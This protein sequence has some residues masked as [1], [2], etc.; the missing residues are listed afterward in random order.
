[1]DSQ[2]HRPE[3]LLR[4]SS[5]PIDAST[6]PRKAAELLR[7][8]KTLMLSDRYGTGVNI[9]TQLRAV[10]NPPSLKAS[11]TERQSFKRAFEQ[12][13]QRLLATIAQ[14]KVALID[15]P[16]NGFYAELYPEHKVFALPFIEVQ[17]LDSAWQYYDV[18]VHMTVLGYRIYPFY[19]TYVP[20]RLSHL[21]LFGTWLA[22]YK[23]AHAQAIDVGTGCGVLALMMCRRGFG[24]V[25]ATDCSPNA[26]E[27]VSREIGRFD[28]P[29][30]LSLEL[31]DLLG[32]GTTP[33]DVIVFNPPWMQGKVNGP[34]DRAL[35]YEAGLF[36]R[37]F[38]QAHQRLSEEGRVVLVFSNLITLVQPDVPH[39]I[40]TELERGRFILVQK[41]SRKVKPSVPKNG[42]RPRK[43]REKVEIWELAR[44]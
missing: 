6:T 5:R 12:A 26:I 3:A 25:L 32:T 16:E 20:S 28:D 18:G 22:Q 31:G 36:E 11:Y 43:T 29:P 37:F 9:L 38:D 34:L 17:R 7:D 15:A 23:G 44:A 24:E 8:G 19:G 27:S 2:L 21:E 33:A 40:E 35:Y 42:G 4:H 14:H 10:L 41:L 30:P 13:S 39:P 1:M